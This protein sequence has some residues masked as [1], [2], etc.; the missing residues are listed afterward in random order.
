MLIKPTEAIKQGW[1]KFP[2]SMTQAQIDKCVQPN[3]VDFTLD[4]LYSLDNTSMA[5]LSETSKLMRVLSKEEPTYGE[6]WVLNQGTVYDGMSN[7]YVTV[8]EGHAAILYTRSTLARNGVFLVSGLYDAGYTGQIGFTVYPVGGPMMLTPGTRV[9]QIA[10]ITADSVGK[11]AGGWNH[12]QG[13][14]YTQGRT[15]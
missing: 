5:V 13:T 1:I 7:I 14:H 8:P 2:E 10:I 11:Y 9:G 12:A 3:A 4:V 15:T 6:A